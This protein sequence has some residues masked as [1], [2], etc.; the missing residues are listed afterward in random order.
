MKLVQLFSPLTCSTL[1]TLIPPSYSSIEPTGLLLPN[2]LL[3]LWAVSLLLDRTSKSPYRADRK[4]ATRCPLTHWSL[5]L[6]AWITKPTR[7]APS[8]VGW[9]HNVTRQRVFLSQNASHG[10]KNK[11]QSVAQCKRRNQ[12]V[13]GL[14]QTGEFHWISQRMQGSKRSH[15]DIWQKLYT[16]TF[17]TSCMKI[18]WL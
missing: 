5:R 17:N 10:K 18:L 9:T 12:V 6:W 7:A 8:Q 3:A 15:L 4:A 2:Q 14:S 11:K 1:E 13:F 16:I